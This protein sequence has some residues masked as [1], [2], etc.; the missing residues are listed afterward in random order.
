[1]QPQPGPLAPEAQSSHREIR[2][3]LYGKRG[4][5]Y[6]IFFEIDEER[7]AVWIL[8]IRRG[9]RATLRPEDLAMPGGR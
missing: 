3:L 1:M 5:V 4:N 2:N 7:N 8:Q 9:A 6:R